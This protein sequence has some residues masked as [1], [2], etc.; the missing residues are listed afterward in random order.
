MRQADTTREPPGG[1]R[2]IAIALMRRLPADASPALL[3][4]GSLPTRRQRQYLSARFHSRLA[5]V[6]LARNRSMP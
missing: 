1:N 3:G 4:G 5:W 2:G 6:G